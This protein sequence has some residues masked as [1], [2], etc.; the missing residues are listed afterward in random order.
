VEGVKQLL[1]EELGIHTVVADPFAGMEI[2]S[3]INQKAL[4]K[5]APRY[6]VAAGL[7]LR[8]FSSWHI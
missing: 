2:S 4:A 8:S 1:S 6:M 3:T 5:T 7:A